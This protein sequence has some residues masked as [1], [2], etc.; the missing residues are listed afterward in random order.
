MDK[1]EIKVGDLVKLR[2]DLE[3]K[4]YYGGN[5]YCKREMKFED[6]REVTFADRDGTFYLNRMGGFWY[7]IEMM[8]EVK[9]P[10][11][12]KK[13]YKRKEEILDKEE[14]EYLSAVIKPFKDKVVGIEKKIDGLRDEYDYILF[15]MI[16]NADNF[17][18][19]IFEK[20]TMYKGME[21]NRKYTL[22]ELGI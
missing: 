22:E 17:N 6:F 10:C 2:D 9:R 8:A 11:Q 7:T 20:N 19:P 12:Y 16:R 1:I 5:Y 4:K 13:I 14:R 3:D 18:L 15:V 21:L